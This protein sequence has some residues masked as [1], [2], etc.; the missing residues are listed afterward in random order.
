MIPITL[1]PLQLVRLSDAVSSRTSPHWRCYAAATP[2]G[3][4]TTQYAG[5]SSDEGLLD[6]V[7]RGLRQYFQAQGANF[8]AHFFSNT[9]PF[10]GE[11]AVRLV[12]APPYMFARFTHGLSR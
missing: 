8:R 7:G 9:L 11:L 3:G 6:D 5:Q 12:A 4:H 10:V 2:H 1:L